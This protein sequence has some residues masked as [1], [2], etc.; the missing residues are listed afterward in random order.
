MAATSRIVGQQVSRSC[1]PATRLREYGVSDKTRRTVVVPINFGAAYY[2]RV[3]T[4]DVTSEDIGDRG[5]SCLWY[6]NEDA[7]RRE[8]TSHHRV[9]SPDDPFQSRY[10]EA[11]DI[12]KIHP[13]S[14]AMEESMVATRPLE[15]ISS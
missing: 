13:M 3:R 15:R 7:V 9:L 8:A 1:S 5:S 10:T 11:L 4:P 6:T 2:Q 12:E 14:T